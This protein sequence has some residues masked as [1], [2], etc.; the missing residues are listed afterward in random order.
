MATEGVSWTL[1]AEYPDGL[2]RCGWPGKDPLYIEY[3]DSEWGIPLRGD[4]ELFERIALEGF[5]AGLS[6][7]TILKRREGFRAAF[8]GFKIEAV[9]EMDSTDVERLMQEVG[10]IRNR[11]KIEA[12][13]HNAR[14]T[15]ALRQSGVTLTDLLWGYAQ[16]EHMRPDAGF[17]W[18]P[19]NEV[20]DRMSKDLR[21]LGFKFV[22]S[23]TLYAMMQAIGIINDHAPGCYRRAE[24]G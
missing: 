1:T 6:W 22:G 24:L 4:D 9:A 10:I 14:L 2:T 16:P 7:I 18:I 5:Q 11:A 13:I 17:D 19:T 21:K 12:T 15:L 20:S 23:T 3:H 8:H